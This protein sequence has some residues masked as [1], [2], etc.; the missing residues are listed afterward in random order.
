MA[1]RRTV[2]VNRDYRGDDA[3]HCGQSTRCLGID[4]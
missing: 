4:D 1:R 2:K 3:N